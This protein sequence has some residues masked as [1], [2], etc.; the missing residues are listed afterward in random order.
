[1]ELW[2]GVECSVVRVGDA[3]RDQTCETG[4]HI[5]EE[6]LALVADLGIRTL[7]Y[8]VVW[9]RVA[10]HRPDEYD[11]N[12]SDRRME[13]LRDLGIRPIVGLL[14]H[15]SGP[16]YTDLLDSELPVAFARYASAVAARYPWVT[17]WTPVNEPGTTARFSGLYGHWYPH[18]RDHRT[19][20]RMLVNQ[21]LAV[22]LSMREIRRYAP[23][24]RLVQTEDLGRTFATPRLAYQATHENER[25]WLSY[26]LLCGRVDRHHPWH[27]T[28]LDA[29]VPAGVLAE[30]SQG[31]AAPDVIGINHYLTS[32]RFLDEDV[33]RYPAGFAGGNG[34]DN[35]ADVEAV[36]INPPPGALGVRARLLEAWERYRRP[37]AVTEAHHGAPE[38][39]ECVRWLHEVW[40]SALSLR[41]AGVDVLAVTVWSLF[42]S[43][44]WRSLLLE[45]NGAYEP[46]P[47]DARG[48]PPRPTALAEA[49]R[50][51]VDHGRVTDLSAR[52]SGWW[53]RD[54]RFYPTQNGQRL[55]RALIG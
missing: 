17:D 2:G 51:L 40:E 19:F 23:A 38:M 34:P 20:C 14:H 16:R 1:M 21:C 12:W 13:L 46:G 31:D 4:H 30:L 6:D 45:R 33:V 36:R 26:D 5:R 43:V 15:G 9:E 28:F 32:D 22:A 50:S 8:P 25:R 41:G 53:L 24:A 37:L 55:P 54:E 44:D 11:W 18:K 49:A 39:I 7:R 29:G 3:W 52:E 35:Y 10:P 42:G 27:R 48:C 47:F